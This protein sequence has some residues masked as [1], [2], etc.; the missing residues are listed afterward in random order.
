MKTRIILAHCYP[1][2]DDPT[3]GL[4]IKDWMSEHFE[5]T[6]FTVHYPFGG[7]S[8]VLQECDQ[9]SMVPVSG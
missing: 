6:D 3:A 9:T 8:A 5:A 1:T 4:F 2:A 7:N